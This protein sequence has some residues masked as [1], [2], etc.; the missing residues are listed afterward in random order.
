MNNF[1]VLIDTNI[2]IPLEDT[3][4]TLEPRLAEIKRICAEN[5]VILKIHPAQRNDLLHDDDE[6]RR[7]IVLSRIEQYPEIQ[8]PPPWKE[9]E[10]DS[11]EISHSNE[12]DKVDNLLLCAVHKNAVR[13]LV[14]EDKDIHRKAKKLGI[15]GRVYYID[16]FFGF[17]RKEFDKKTSIPPLGIREVYLHELDKGIE[18][19][20]SLRNGYDEFDEWFDRVSQSERKAW[21]V[22]DTTSPLALV[23]RKAEQNEIITSDDIA[24]P[25]NA[26]KLCTFKVSQ[27]WR[28][29]KIGER[30]LYTAFRYAIEQKIDWV[31]L[32]AFGEEQK[33]L[34]S[35]CE[36]Y[37]FINRGLDKKNARDS[38]YVKDMRKPTGDESI[39]NLEYAIK[40][41]PFYR[42]DNCAKWIIPI[43]PQWHEQL[44]PDIK[45]KNLFSELPESFSASA[46]TIKKA[47]LCHAKTTKMQ[48]GD[49]LYFYRSE[50]RRTVECVGIVE[51]TFRSNDSQEIIAEVSK[52]TVYSNNDI[53]KIAKKDTLV[54][55]FRL[56]EYITPISSTELEKRGVKQ[57][58]QS[59]R[60]VDFLL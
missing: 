7:N 2:I 14:T 44:F 60:S 3:S 40:H 4:R 56:L 48:Q 21:I 38:V 41:Y 27:Q 42:K 17:L 10:L 34:I 55:L 31:Y 15:E 53:D 24:L 25:G 35:L 54:I 37:G 23:I 18:F 43:Q 22:G 47:Y 52:R 46:N 13:F 50:D 29:R 59:I 12:N 32:T 45:D 26:L 49:L 5:S 33:M 1:Y 36:E 58:I 30:L 57:P 51:K 8:Q 9:D 11:L 39:T 20:N 16:Q 19:F 6:A 28:G